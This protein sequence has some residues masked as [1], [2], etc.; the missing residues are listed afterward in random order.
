MSQST[1]QEY[2]ET[3]IEGE[4]EQYSSAVSKIL[5]EKRDTLRIKTGKAIETKLQDV[6][7]VPLRDLSGL[8]RVLNE[9]SS[10]TPNHSVLNQVI[11]VHPA[12]ERKIVINEDL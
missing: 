4:W 5:T 7:N 9:S 11:N 12:L 3:D 1:V 2:I 10:I 6:S 8:Y